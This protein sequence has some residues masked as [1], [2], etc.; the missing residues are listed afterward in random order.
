[1]AVEKNLV[2]VAGVTLT[3]SR[4]A[5]VVVK[6]FNNPPQVVAFCQGGD[7]RMLN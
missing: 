2:P 7:L 3:P 4:A 6:E 5:H 1:M